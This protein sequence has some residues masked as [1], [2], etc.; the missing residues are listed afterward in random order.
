MILAIIATW[1]SLAVL[2]AVVF[3]VLGRRGLQEEQ[4]EDVAY[5]LSRANSPSPVTANR[6]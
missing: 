3:A 1:L 4:A 6:A 5:L 2:T